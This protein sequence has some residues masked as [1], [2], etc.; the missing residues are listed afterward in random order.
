[1]P[2][3]QRPLENNANNLATPGKTA[4]DYR[5]QRWGVRGSLWEFSTLNRVKKCGR[6]SLGGMVEVRK[7]GDA[8]GLAGLATCGSVWAC[9]CCNA[10]IQARRRM[11]VGVALSH[12]LGNG[13]SAAFGSLT[14]R[15]HKGTNPGELWKAISKCWESVTRDRTVKRLRLDMGLLGIV[16]TAEITHG[17]NGWHPH[18]HPLFLFKEQ[19]TAQQVQQLHAAQFRAWAAAAARLGLETPLEAAQDLH[20]VRGDTAD[21]E[22]SD[23]MAKVTWE[24]TSTQTKNGGGRTPWQIFADFRTTADLED[25]E[26][27]QRFEQFSKGKRSITWSRGLRK[28]VGLDVEKTDEEIAA[29]TLGSKEDTVVYIEDWAP[30]RANP[31]WGGEMLTVLQRDG[32][33]A[34]IAWLNRHG[35]KWVKNG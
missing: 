2:S 10:K 1:M 12:T 23:Y 5:A 22:L 11:E 24:M 18:I 34:V 19:V 9:P 28:L 21:K 14:L 32:E 17:F 8:V 15:H 29:E 26:L 13:G 31:T 35:V 4:I 6:V 20:L 25:L 16:R 27:W 30:F 7:S 33:E 3:L